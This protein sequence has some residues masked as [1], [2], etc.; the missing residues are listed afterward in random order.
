MVLKQEV[1]GPL[2]LPKHQAEGGTPASRGGS[3]MEKRRLLGTPHSL[4]T[5]ERQTRMGQD[6]QG[7]HGAY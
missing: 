5:T 1:D 7:E 6:R 3:S 4:E 2:H